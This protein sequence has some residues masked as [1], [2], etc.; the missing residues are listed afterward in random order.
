MD[1]SRNMS[2]IF[3]SY[4]R[5]EQSAARKLADALEKKGWSV[6]WDPKLRA[7][8]R[9]DDAIEEA[10]KGAKSVIVMWSKLSVRSRYVRDEATYA[11]NRDKLVPI[12]IEKVEL[13]FRFEGIQTEELINWD[14]SENFSG[15]QKLIAD[16]ISILG[17]PPIEERKHKAI[18]KTFK[19]SFG[20]EFVLIPAGSFTMGSRMSL[21]ELVDRFGGGKEL[22]EFEKPHHTVKIERSFYLQTTPVTQ[23]Q[24]ERVIGNNPSEFNDCGDDCPVEQV[25]WNDVQQFIKKLNQI[26]KT[27]DYRLPSEAEWEYA[28]RA[29]SDAEFSFGDDVAMLNEFGWYKDNSG[30][31]PHP[32]RGKKPNAWGLYDMHGNVWE[33]VEDDWHECY[34]GAPA[35]NSAW[36][37]NPRGSYRVFRGGS[38]SYDARGCRSAMR[39]GI[40]P[41]DRDRYVGF[42]LSRSVAL[43]P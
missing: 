20:M 28:C 23:G 30:G 9:F 37:D 3:I 40:R 16:L 41:G 32:V 38:W 8:E 11:L 43:G 21:K 34:E 26:E 27:K 5:E 35:D 25:S 2:D 4:K 39:Y 6:W 19:N 33:W 22:F 15:Y 10:L 7:G 12:K 31:K 1:A 14:G 29:G 24:W 36:V 17:N 13:P 42:R 18:P